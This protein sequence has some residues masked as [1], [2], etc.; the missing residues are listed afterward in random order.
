MVILHFLHYNTRRNLT[1]TVVRFTGP[2]GGIP[3]LSLYL[4]L[5]LGRW[6]WFTVW[7]LTPVPLD[8]SWL[9]RESIHLVVFTGDLPN[10]LFEGSTGFS[11]TTGYINVL[12]PSTKTKIRTFKNIVNNVS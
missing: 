7:T 6:L 4:S 12:H 11:L 8:R 5:R 3:F 2:L 9:N 10:R 1:T